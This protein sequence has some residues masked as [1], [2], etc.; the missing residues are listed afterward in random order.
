MRTRIYKRLPSNRSID[1]KGKCNH[2]RSGRF[3][4]CTR[5]LLG[6]KTSVCE[7]IRT[8]EAGERTKAKGVHEEEKARAFDVRVDD[9]SSVE[10]PGQ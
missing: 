4:R 5:L 8:N 1:A 7:T 10:Q 9:S 6:K 2:E 3:L